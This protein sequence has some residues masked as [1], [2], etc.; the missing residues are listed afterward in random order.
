[1]D[2]VKA[3]EEHQAEILNDLAAVY[4][5]RYGTRAALHRAAVSRCADARTVERFRADSEAAWS[6]YL[7]VREAMQALGFPYVWEPTDWGEARQ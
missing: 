1:M 2:E 4:L 5:A 7:G 3:L 6:E